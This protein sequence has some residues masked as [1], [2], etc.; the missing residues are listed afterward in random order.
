[1]SRLIAGPAVALLLSAAAAAAV[2][3]ESGTARASAAV[4]ASSSQR[5]P[6]I[7]LRS[8]AGRQRAV[9]GSFCVTGPVEG[10]WVTLC[11]DTIDPEPRW[12]SVVRPKERVTI[13]VRGATSARGVVV[14]HPRGCENRIAR[15]FYIRRSTKRWVVQLEPGRYELDVSISEFTTSDGRSGDTTAALGL[16]V[17]ETRA[18]DVIPANGS[19][20]CP[21]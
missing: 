14:V 17:S 1:M 6:P 4:A 11:A 5:P 7:V 21:R 16:L 3:F 20:A 12:L 19:L 10:G 2:D 9:Q 13:R 8:T 18:T 15:T